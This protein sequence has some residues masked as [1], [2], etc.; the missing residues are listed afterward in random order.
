M[1]G[2]DPHNDIFDRRVFFEVTGQNIIPDEFLDD[3]S[4]N[5]EDKDH[6]EEPDDPLH[7]V[8]AHLEENADGQKDSQDKLLPVMETI[9]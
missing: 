5:E 1:S 4:S 7:Y 8:F 6:Q 2:F 3:N 9:N